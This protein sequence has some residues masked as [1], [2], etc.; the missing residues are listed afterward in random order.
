[1][2]VEPFDPYDVLTDEHMAWY[3]GGRREVF[4]LQNQTDTVYNTLKRHTGYAHSVRGR[5]T[6]K[7]VTRFFGTG[8]SANLMRDLLTREHLRMNLSSRNML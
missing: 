7:D 8:W 6:L 1:M 3:N 5:P 4:A 2:E